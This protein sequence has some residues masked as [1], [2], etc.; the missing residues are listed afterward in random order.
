MAL[1]LLLIFHAGRIIPIAVAA[2][3][4]LARFVAENPKIIGSTL[5]IEAISSAIQ[6]YVTTEREKIAYMETDVLI[7]KSQYQRLLDRYKS[8]A[9]AD[10]RLKK[11]EDDVDMQKIISEIT[12]NPKMSLQEVVVN[13]PEIIKKIMKNI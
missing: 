13:H 3:T 8:E 12:T 4:A 2:G 6:S 5:S 1:P 7:L 10:A 9:M 11:K